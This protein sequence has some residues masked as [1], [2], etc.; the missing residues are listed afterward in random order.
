MKKFLILISV[1][2]VA[3]QFI[4]YSQ[5]GF[6]VLWKIDNWGATHGASVTQMARFSPDGK[7]IYFVVEN[8]SGDKSVVFQVSSE[9]GETISQSER[10]DQ[11]YDFDMSE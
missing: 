9:T 5:T 10:I 4:G 2:F 7:S 1:V 6:D 11:I 8:G 3:V